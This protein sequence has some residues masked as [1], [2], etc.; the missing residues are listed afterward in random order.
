MIIIG[1][2]VEN[3]TKT[4]KIT[5]FC[6]NCSEKVSISI[7]LSFI[8]IVVVI[9]HLLPLSSLTVITISITILF[10]IFVFVFRMNE[11]RLQIVISKSICGFLLTW[12]GSIG[13]QCYC[14]WRATVVFTNF[15]WLFLCQW[16]NMFFISFF[17]LFFFVFIQY[18]QKKSASSIICKT[19]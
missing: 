2:R 1:K 18:K 14:C 3:A 17:F 7:F 19:T 5:D 10:I 8:F 4:H 15:S 16:F 6:S 9:A 13:L 11:P 12:I